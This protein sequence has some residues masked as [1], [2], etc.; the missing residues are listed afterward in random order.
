M[1]HF[2]DVYRPAAV[3]DDD[4]LSFPAEFTVQDPFCGFL[5]PEL[6]PGSREMSDQ[7]GLVP[8]LQKTG[9]HIGKLQDILRIFHQQHLEPAVVQPD[10]FPV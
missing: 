8:I 10:I 1:R 5:K 2:H 3:F 9:H 6:G 4:F 7:L